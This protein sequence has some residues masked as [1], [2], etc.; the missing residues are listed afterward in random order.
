MGPRHR[1]LLKVAKGTF[2]PELETRL[3]A[4]LLLALRK[5]PDLEVISLAVA[6]SAAR[7]RHVCA[8]ENFAPCRDKL[9]GVEGELSVE[10][11]AGA[12]PGTWLLDPAFTPTG[13]ERVWQL[14][15]PFAPQNGEPLEEATARA[16]TQLG[17]ALGPTGLRAGTSFEPATKSVSRLAAVCDGLNDPAGIDLWSARDVV[18]AHLHRAGQDHQVGEA[19]A[20]LKNAGDAQ[21]DPC[22]R[23]AALDTW[24]SNALSRGWLPEKLQSEHWHANV[25]VVVRGGGKRS[26]QVP[27]LLNAVGG[28]LA[29]R[30][31]TFETGGPEVEG[32]PCEGADCLGGQDVS[33]VTTTLGLLVIDVVETPKG[34]KSSATFFLRNRRGQ[35]SPPRAAD[36]EWAPGVSTAAFDAAIGAMLTD[37]LQE[38]PELARVPAP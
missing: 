11:Q 25:R 21:L 27:A 13:G 5:Q 33:D 3:E 4:E 15:L 18:R 19:L 35:I 34:L 7:R 37:A 32:E 38:P 6:D 8:D 10:L 28:A 26:T 14:T 20:H 31:F 2:A 23:L 1:V 9:L 12:V 30:G 36:F 16:A 22:A 24:R 17:G 29:T